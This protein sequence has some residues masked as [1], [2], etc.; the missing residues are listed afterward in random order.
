MGVGAAGYPAAPTPIKEA[1]SAISIPLAAAAALARRFALPE[2][3]GLQQFAIHLRDDVH[4]DLLRAD[5]RAL[6]D[7]GAAAEPLGVHPLDH[8]DHARVAL[9]LAL[10]QQ[11][12]V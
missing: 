11:P 10:R 4:A 1:G 8:A 7:V 3:R 6:A 12:Q 9:G 5:G 2:Q